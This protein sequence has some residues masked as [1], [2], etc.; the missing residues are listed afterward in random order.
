MAAA[1][2]FAVLAVHPG[3]SAPAQA[4]PL[5]EAAASDDAPAV[6]QGQ[7]RY[8]ATRRIVVDKQTRQL[9]MPTTQEVDQLVQNLATLT[10]RS[11]EGLPQTEVPG[12]GV[13]VDLDGGFGGVMLARPN[14]DGT[15]ETRCVFTFEEGAEFLGLVR[16]EA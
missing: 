3:T 6:P 16:E 11:S 10:K 13:G 12:G 9:R 8:K 4:L 14:E 1:G 5:A 2:F 15:F 7:G